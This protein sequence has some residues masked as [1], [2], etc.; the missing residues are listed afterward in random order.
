MK[1]KFKGDVLTEKKCINSILRFYELASISEVKDGLTWYSEA[2][3]YAREL[4][5][6]FDISIQQVVGLI[7]AFS[8]QAGWVENKRYTVTFLYNPNS[9]IRSQV[10]TDK[11]KLILSYLVESDIYNALSTR[12]AAYK[13]KAFFKNILNPDIDSD[14]TI[15]RHA[16]ASCLQHPDNV[17]A[18]DERYGQL[19][20]TQYEFFQN[21][22]I[23]AARQVNIL[24][25]QLQAI[26]WVTY[27]RIRKLSEH[28]TET[29]W[30]PF[31]TTD[32][33]PF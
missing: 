21:C 16:I 15:D 10:Q 6:R 14:V 31:A 33:N 9:R 3:K 20:S 30:Q 8:P 29:E 7:A 12:G 18:L 19:T 22:Y 13:T 5:A 28:T 23:K 1:Q 26:V 25:H 11:A 4:A 27:R 2:N 24:P 17:S 32:E